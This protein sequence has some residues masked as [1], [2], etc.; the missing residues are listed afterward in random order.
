VARVK[1]TGTRE[2]ISMAVTAQTAVPPGRQA[3]TAYAWPALAILAVFA[4][5]IALLRWEGRLWWCAGGG[6]TLWSGDA[7]G[8]H[9]SQHPFDPYS[10]THVL[11]GVILC[12]L[13]SW[14]APRLPAAW[15]LCLAVAL[16]AAWE[17]IENSNVVIDHYRTATAAL[18]YRG[19]TVVNSLGDIL[20]CVVGYLLARRLGPWW[21]LALFVV[22]EVV[23][24]IWIR[25][26][27]ALEVLMLLYPIAAIKRWQGGA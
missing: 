6:L 24:L 16:E 23:L 5:H 1:E 14:L 12:G 18:G 27:L 26:S 4:I 25:D 22:I 19:D 21:S 8:P 20:S 13:L 2:T 3:A 7:W 9:T 17:V 15:R 10:L 11:H